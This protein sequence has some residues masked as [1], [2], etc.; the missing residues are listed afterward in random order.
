MIYLH[1]INSIEELNIVP[2]DKGIEFDVRE[3]KGEIVI[4]HDFERP[5]PLLSDFLKKAKDHKLIINVKSEGLI[6][7]VLSYLDGNQI[8]NYFF[9]DLNYPEMVKL[10]SQ[11][12]FKFAVRLSEYESIN[13]SINLNPKWIWVDCFN[14]YDVTLND[15]KLIREAGAKICLVSP[16]LQS[17]KFDIS[18]VPEI[19]RSEMDA[20]CTKIHNASK[21]QIFFRGRI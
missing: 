16:E 5:G 20:V 14:H 8:T 12:N 7:E 19:L 17:K 9:L 11:G 15:I 21:W 10:H 3:Y 6:E 18:A 13:K 2:S 4:A 1:R